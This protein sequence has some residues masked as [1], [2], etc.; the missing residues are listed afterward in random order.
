[1]SGKLNGVVQ[2]S[3]HARIG[4]RGGGGPIDPG[5]RGA[6]FGPKPPSPLP[7]DCFVTATYSVTN[8]CKLSN[9]HIVPFSEQLRIPVRKIPK[10]L[11]L[12]CD[13]AAT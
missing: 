13:G 9:Y 8:R 4:A 2:Q 3:R 5:A 10:L 12:I 7:D 1:M 11:A 6:Q